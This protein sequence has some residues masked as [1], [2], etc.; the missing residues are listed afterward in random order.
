MVIKLGGFVSFLFKRPVAGRRMK[1]ESIAFATDI[2]RN[3][4]CYSLSRA[5][6]TTISDNVGKKLEHFTRISPSPI[7][8]AEFIE[9][10]Q[11]GKMSSAESYTHLVQEALV[12]LSHMISE[13]RQFP[14][15]LAEQEEYK[16][17]LSEY[18]ITYTKLLNFENK[19]ANAK[20]ISEAVELLIERKARHKETVPSMA[21]ACMAMKYKYGVSLDEEDCALTKSVQYCLDRLYISRISLN[22]LTNQHLMVHGYKKP[23]KHQVGVIDPRTNLEEIVRHAYSNARFMCEKCYI[24]APKLELKTHNLTDP[25]HSVLVVHVPSHIYH[26]S[27]EVMKN[28]MQAT[29]NNNWGKLDELPPIKVLICQ[30]DNDITIKISDL[31][32]GVDRASSDKMFKYLYSTSPK[33]SLTKESVPLSGLGYGLPLA[34]LYARY[35]QGDIKAAS[36][37]N[38]GTDI[39]IYLRALAKESVE[40]LPIW[41][42]T[43]S[44]KISATSSD[45]SDWTSHRSTEEKKMSY[46]FSK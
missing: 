42:D 25:E 19:E 31:G 10:G 16:R 33:V 21:S 13:M 46:C 7:S 29:V 17:V 41:S 23:I 27:F 30:S 9:R 12:R 28:A 5:Y 35:F 44:S 14:K 39:Y 6:T 15:E 38:H 24:N 8:M 36:Y 26:M 43:A 37:E 11:A 20:N 40:Q 2:H 22:M 34:R 18:L 3:R 4:N 32:G 1:L 45:I